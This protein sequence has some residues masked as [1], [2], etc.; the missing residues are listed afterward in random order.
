LFAFESDEMKCYA[1]LFPEFHLLYYHWKHFLCFIIF[2]ARFVFVCLNKI[3]FDWGKVVCI[4]RHSKW[5]GKQD[6]LWVSNFDGSA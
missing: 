5:R 3:S 6:F 1:Q 2:F 4:V